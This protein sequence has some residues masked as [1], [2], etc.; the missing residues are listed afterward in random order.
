MPYINILNENNLIIGVT[1]LH[2]RYGHTSILQYSSAI[3]NNIIIGSN[4]ILILPAIFFL[5][6]VGYFFE[7][8]NNKKSDNLIRYISFIFLSYCLINM[9]RYSSWGNDDFASILFP[10]LHNRI[11]QIIFKF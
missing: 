9:N 3:F 5:S 6:L 8:I 1:N 7:N 10:N 2:F 11:I 4:G